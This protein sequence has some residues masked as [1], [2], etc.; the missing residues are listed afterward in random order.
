MKKIVS[1]PVLL[2][3]LTPLV[4]IVPNAAL[5]IT[6]Q[7]YG[8]PARIANVLLPWGVY[9]LFMA[10]TRRTG[11]AA[12]CTL[13]IMVLCAFQ[14]VLL[15]LYGESIIAIDMFLNVVTTNVHEATE[16]LSNLVRAIITV[17]L[18][19]LPLLV[20]AIVVCVKGDCS[21]RAERRPLRIAG[22]WSAIAGVVAVVWAW[23][24]AGY[25]IERELF[26]V[27]V[28]YNIVQAAGR[29]ED[30]KNYS[31]TSA[32]YAF[33]AYATDTVPSIVVMV[34]G[35]TSR[36]DN[37]QLL[38]Y[39]RETNPLMSRRDGVVAYPMALSQ[40]NTTHKSVPLM[41]SPLN[42]AT[43]GDS[44]YNVKSVITAFNEAGYT[45]AW[46][47]NQQRNGALID[48][49]GTEAD[50]TLFLHD[51]GNAHYDMELISHVRRWVADNKGK[52]LLI[53]LHTYGSHFNYQERYPTEYKHFTPDNHLQADADN[54]DRLINAFDNT[55]RYADALLDSVAAVVEADSRP[56]AMLYVAD[57]GE[58]IFDD[59]RGRFLHASPTPTW[60]QLHVPVVIWMSQAYRDLYPQRYVSAGNNSGRQVSSSISAF[61]TLMELGGVEAPCVDLTASLVDEKY[62]EP[63]FLYLDDYNEAVPLSR[64]GLRQPDFD[65]LQKAGINI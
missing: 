61:H 35:E 53:V 19:Y 41:L 23:T 17:C 18:V 22:G 20:V 10:C 54:R 33:G 49:F 47:S 43:Y 45:T 4:L 50:T 24:G 51:D 2:M 56:S 44:I 38:G 25:R 52:P 46:M 12:L 59:D 28:C 1:L 9:C 8:L 14:I 63:T 27:N 21:T 64:A 39:G 7:Y 26:P 5:D 62:V 30:A 65:S 48:A 42:A 55:I 3:W 37:W 31:A 6:E 36:A 16:L 29:T 32:S 13:P 15:Y 57:H 40:S 34:V 58:D 11:V 60:H